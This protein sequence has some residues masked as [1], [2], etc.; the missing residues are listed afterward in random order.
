MPDTQ[1]ASMERDRQGKALA[2]GSSAGRGSH[3]DAGG[4]GPARP[5]GF[6]AQPSRWR[7]VRV[8][9]ATAL[10]L[11]AWVAAATS[12]VY[13]PNGRL[14]VVKNDAGE[15]ARYVYDPMGNL[16]RIDRIAANA[17]AVFG[18]APGRGSPGASVRISGQGFSPTPA[19]N[20]VKF[21]GVAATVTAATASELTATV[22]AGATTG[23]IS[24]AV[25][26]ASASSVSDFVIDV[27]AQPPVITAVGP[28]VAAIGTAITVDG[29]HL[30]PVAEQTSVRLGGRATQPSERT[31]TRTVF[32]VPATAASGKVSVTTPYGTATSADDVLVVPPGVSPSEIELRKRLSVDAPAQGFSIAGTGKYAAVLFDS[33]GGEFLSAQFSAISVGSLTY[34]LFGVDN[35]RLAGGT[36]SPASPSVHLPK[37]AAA[38]TYLLLLQPASVAATWNLAIERAAVLPLDGAALSLDTAVAAQSKRVVF[39]AAPGADLGFGLSDHATP[40]VWTS[41]SVYAYGPDGAQV[42]YQSCEQ[43]KNGC[44]LNFSDVLAGVY[45]LV[46]Q[47]AQSGAQTLG[48]E[49]S[50]SSDASATLTRDV[51]ATLNLA[52]RG[53]NGRLSFDGAAGDVVGL[54]VAG[55]QTVPAGRTAYYRVHKPDGTLWKSTALTTGATMNLALP[56]TGRYQVFVDPEFGET[57]TAQVLLSS[58]TLARPALDGASS[59]FATTQPGQGVYLAIDASA[60]Q[61]LGLGLSELTLSSGAGV[62]VNAYRPDG[63]LQANAV[64]YAAND[65][66][67]LNLSNLVAGRYAVEIVPAADQ[68]MAFKATLSTDA[69]GALARD[70]ASVQ[71]I[72][73]RGQNAR[74][75]FPGVIGDT[76]ALRIAAQTTTPAASG[77]Y[78]RI[79]KPDGSSLGAT[80]ASGD[81][82]L[83]LE[84]PLTGDYQIMVDPEYGATVSA[85]LKIIAGA[86]GVLE[87]DGSSGKHETQ[88][89]EEVVLTFAAQAGQHLG[90]G[91]SDLTVNTGSY[92]RVYAYRPNGTTLLDDH[93]CYIQNGGCGI[94]FF[95]PVAGTYTVKIK[96]T[97]TGQ[98]MKFRSTL[99]SAAGGTLTRDMPATLNLDRRGQDGFYTFT[100][101]AGEMLALQIA[102]QST[103]PA[104]R[105]VIYRVYE[106]N[107]RTI[108]EWSVE[109]TAG[110]FIS[111]RLPANG[112]YWVYVDPDAGAAA[113]AQ[114]TLSTG[115][116]RSLVPDGASDSVATTLPGQTAHYRVNAVAGQNLGFGI[117][118][119]GLST[120]S[121]ARVYAFKPD[122]NK[123]VDDRWCRIEDGGCDVNIFNA[124][125]GVYSILVLPSRDDQAMQF[126]A[127]LSSAQTGTLGRD[128]PLSLNLGRRGQDGLL[129]F[130]GTVNETLAL[131]VAGQAALPAG[132]VVYR[133]YEPNDRVL[134]EWSLDSTTGGFINMRLPRTGTYWVYVDPVNGSTAASQVT[135]STGTTSTMVRDGA[136]ASIETG[137]P[138]QTAHFRFEA[139]AGE[140]LGFGLSDLVLSSGSYVRVFAFRP[141]GSRLV[142]DRWC[143]VSEG[144]CD[145]SVYNAMAGSYS[146]LVLPTGDDQAMQFKA[147]LSSAL[148]AVLDR[149]TTTTLALNRRGRDGFLTFSGTAGES[150]TLQ[151]AAQSTLPAGKKVVYRVYEPNDRSIP[152]WSL[153]PSAGG[154][155]NMRLPRTGTYWLYI[156]PV[157]G[158]T[159]TTQVT[160]STGTTSGLVKDGPSLDAATTLP[161]QTLHFRYDAAAG[162]NVGFGLSDLVVNTASYVRV[163]AFRPDGTRLLDDRW[164]YASEGGCDV[165]LYNT[166]AGTYSIVILPRTDDQTM[167]FKATL[168]SSHSA[169]LA[170]DVPTTLN[171]NRRGQ[172]ALLTFAGAAGETLALRVAGQSTAPAGYRVVYRVFEPNDRVLPDWSLQPTVDGSVNMTLPRAGTYWIHV[173]PAL[174]ATAET[175]ITLD[176]TP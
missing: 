88:A 137:Q 17:L 61:N 45:S 156:D 101:A 62:S 120:G 79:Y 173:D 169:V 123:L 108:A 149:D 105:R 112:T 115:T 73:R 167:Q 2:L 41:A 24:V 119:L 50:L 38:G 176:S 52:R 151:I 147:T 170:R 74:L 1:E 100:G 152:D 158:A 160:L 162:E 138:G 172:D 42:G 76:I 64:C 15:S 174:G 86:V 44:S 11:W 140:N 129:T 78:Y 126:K 113:T 13:D 98:T 83:N 157:N 103:A 150:L 49:A 28:L 23:P 69:T 143:H 117:S 3:G 9:L 35:K 104:G 146:I 58:G 142:D 27:D 159:A 81:K 132:K 121:Y 37:L 96:P 154:F 153:E 75:S 21:N 39:S 57:L 4:A 55:Q 66:C 94:N 60:G 67:D 130:S 34:T 110:G 54:L 31:D 97:S 56:T 18:F 127:T 165:N 8:A 91:I 40:S 43:S 125:A 48:F 116:A 133:V 118:E 92:V 25:G 16:L 155:I 166:M 164:C 47:P 128:T 63:S 102:G 163:Y 53:Q 109:P 80:Y 30:L 89:G 111:M 85:E 99:S 148:T 175:Q 114:L 77:V 20:G 29:Q 59:S 84:L 6:F 124:T 14:V 122:G 51:A 68:T 90:L 72:A 106:P 131:Q 144:G 141:D 36:V 93:W 70:V 171:L 12:Y 26:A 19:Q 71:T 139:A 7:S 145:I 5:A 46:I 33:S 10:L 168:S 32:P 136:S 87:L 161:G 135:L 22:P 107:D 65:G 82:T 134:S 95:N